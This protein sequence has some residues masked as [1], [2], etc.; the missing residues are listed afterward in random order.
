M[1]RINNEDMTLSEMGQ[2]MKKQLSK[3]A[4]YNRLKKLM[5]MAEDVEEEEYELPIL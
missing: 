5:K 2:K 1:I 3:S 4:V